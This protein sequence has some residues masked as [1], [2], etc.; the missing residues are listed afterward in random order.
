MKRGG[1]ATE[2]AL[3]QE[4]P[5]AVHV[6]FTA[7]ET[8]TVLRTRG[9]D[10]VQCF[11]LAGAPFESADDADVNRWHEQL[12]VLWRSIAAPQVAVWAHVVRRRD[13]STLAGRCAPGFAAELDSLYRAR[14]AGDTLWV[15]DL[16]LSIVYRAE[17]SAVE[18]AGA[19]VLRRSGRRGRAVARWQTAAALESC[20]KLAAQVAASLS[21][22]RP[23]AL[24]LN[25]AGGVVWSEI[26]EFLAL[27]VNGER[28]ATPA[29]RSPLAEALVTARLLFGREV[30]EYRTASA[31]RLGAMLGVK[32]YPA[33]TTPGVFNRLLAAPFPFVLTQSF[34]FLAKGTAQGLLARQYHRMINAGDLAISQAEAL[35]AAL[36]AVASNEFVMGDHHFALQV[37]S[38]PYPAAAISE[39]EAAQ[40]IG[41]LNDAVAQARNLLADSGMVIAR[42]DI[43]LEAAFWAQLPGNFAY[44]LR[45]SPI[46]SRNFAAFAPWHNYPLGRAQGNHWGEALAILKSSAGSPYFFSLHASDP[47]DAEGGSRRDTGH[48]FLCGPTGSGKTVLLGFLVAQLTKCGARQVIFDKDRGL[49]ILVRALGGVYLPIRSGAPSGMNPL[50]LAPTA[51]NLEFLRGWLRTLAGAGRTLSVREEADLDTALAGTMGLAAGSRRLSRLVEFLDPTDAEGVGAR[52]SRWCERPDRLGRAGEDAWVFDNADDAVASLLAA[53]DVVG[54]DVTA[55]LD[56]PR[57][58][59]PVAMYLFHLVRQRLDGARTVVWMDEFSRLLADPAF[60]AFAKD[61]LKTWR[62]L[63]G[64]AGFATQS[65][66]DVIDSPIA[67]TLIEQSPTKIFFPNPDASAADYREGFGLTAREF[68]LVRD[69]LAPGSRRFLVKQGQESVVCELDLKGMDL[70]LAVISGRLSNVAVVERLRVECGGEPGQWLPR[71]AEY[72]QSRRGES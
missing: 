45:R 70:E 61:G 15:N 71:F 54:F 16:Y 65:P 30:I 64:V 55:F 62:K 1:I 13:R 58:R 63:N 21:R 33:L 56:A 49:E 4:R 11:G 19:R 3:R 2:S 8:P 10:Y 5:A 18:S 40:R 60:T 50:A 31:S 25:L 51:E 46:T 42:E 37:M 14:L 20:E 17:G 53:S 35:K 12:N 48:T 43:A 52:L 26:A 47:N 68:A 57:L 72:V 6:P 34:A 69:E 39:D 36:D 27:L 59:E 41:R 44:R 24:T 67:R 22:Y 28:V 38:E 32:E 29:P 66:S 7:H 23:V 9:G